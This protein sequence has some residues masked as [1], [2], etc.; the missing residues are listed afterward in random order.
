MAGS[1]DTARSSSSSP[2]TAG[3]VARAG[4]QSDPSDRRRLASQIELVVQAG[5]YITISGPSYRFSRRCACCRRRAGSPRRRRKHRLHP[6]RL[7]EV[8]RRS[9][10]LPTSGRV[11][12]SRTL[13]PSIGCGSTLGACPCIAVNELSR[14]TS[15]VDPSAL[16][17]G[18][19]LP[20]VSSLRETQSAVVW[21]GQLI[22]TLLRDAPPRAAS[23][24]CREFALCKLVRTAG[25]R[26]RSWDRPAPSSGTVEDRF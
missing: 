13:E 8:A 17:R 11:K 9:Q 5:A 19:G 14:C 18:P 12:P 1:G 26:S 3:L 6:R 25:R 7:T 16:R 23:L 15:T 22:A 21:S 10:A 20:R 24:R 2:P 4:G